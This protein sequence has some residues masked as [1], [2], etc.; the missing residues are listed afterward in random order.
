MSKNA[1]RI[2]SAAA[3][4]SAVALV[5][6]A[7]AG[8]SSTGSLGSTGSTGSTG[9]AGSSETTEAPEAFACA[10]LSTKTTPNG[11][12]NPFDD[13]VRQIAYHTDKKVLDEDGS[14]KLEVFGTADRSASYHEAGG[15]KLSDAI[16][17]EIGF[18][19][20]GANPQASFQL[21]LTGTTDNEKYKDNGFTTL[22]WVPDA[23]AADTTEGYTHANLQ[24]G[25]WWSTSNI[26]G[27][28]GRALVPL[29]DIAAA[30]PDAVVDHYGVSIGRGS[31]ET[32]TLVDAVKF[33]GCTTNFA[34]KD[35]APSETDSP[36]SGSLGSAGSSSTG[37]LGS[38]DLGSLSTDS[39]GS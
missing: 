15:I 38:L 28:T 17:Q 23:D 7:I 37:S 5:A 36:E 6:P 32:S 14:L 30:N 39:L 11:W 34:L 3:I 29:A 19:E 18:S 21:R 33:N 31:E 16:K 2:G 10:E 26:A 24:D 13:E 27:A 9:S 8:A 12:G 20:R 4:L 25:K 1:F 35:P 22:V